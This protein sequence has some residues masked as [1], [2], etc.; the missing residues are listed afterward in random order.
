MVFYLSAVHVIM[1]KT[2]TE[3]LICPC[4]HSVSLSSP[5][6]TVAVLM[7]STHRGHPTAFDGKNLCR[8]TTPIPHLAVYSGITYSPS[9]NT[10]SSLSTLAQPPAWPSP[11]S[12][13]LDSTSTS[14]R[15]AESGEADQ[16][17]EVGGAAGVNVCKSRMA[18]SLR[19]LLKRGCGPS[20]VFASL[21][22]K[23][24][25]TAGMSGRIQPISP[26]PPGQAPPRR[27][28]NF[29]Q[30]K[31]DIPPECRIYPIESEDEEDENR[32]TVGAKEIIC[33]WE[34]LTPPNGTS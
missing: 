23:C 9:T 1:N 19:R 8:F 27:M 6:S 4:R 12:V 32:A 15:R 34:S 30:I 20:A 21:S 3:R 13:A 25:T 33:P 22:P 24:H 28:G 2:S 26:D 18:L 7:S 10:S 17:G 11:I 31:V 5:M 14:E 16:D 29:F